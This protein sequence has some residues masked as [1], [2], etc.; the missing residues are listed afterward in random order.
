M[1]YKA[2]MR[3]DRALL[4]GACSCCLAGLCLALCGCASKSKVDARN[5]F[6]EGQQ[7]AW[8]AQQQNQEP[9]VFFRGMVRNPRVPWTEGLTL[10]R[11][12]LAAEY[13]GALDPTQIRVTRDGQVYVIDV[14]RLMRGQDDPLLEPGDA[15]EVFR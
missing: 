14:K 10:A 3:G 2:Y 15:V 5:A 8:S 13:T 11:A 6:L 1:G 4:L 12:L 7:R 9:T